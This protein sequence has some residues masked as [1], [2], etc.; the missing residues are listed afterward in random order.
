MAPSSPQPVAVA[1]LLLALRLPLCNTQQARGGGT[2]A[3]APSA[4][5]V[6]SA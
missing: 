3:A 6:P 2:I 5:R 1:V 4:F